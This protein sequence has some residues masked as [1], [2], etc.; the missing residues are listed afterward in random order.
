[1]KS[2]TKIEVDNWTAEEIDSD[3]NNFAK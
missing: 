1:M 3:F 2:K